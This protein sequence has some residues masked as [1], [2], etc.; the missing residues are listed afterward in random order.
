[1]KEK[2]KRKLEKEIKKAQKKGIYN[3]KI[4]LGIV[5]LILVI[6]TVI[7]VSYAY[8]EEQSTTVLIINA[9]VSKKITINVKAT[10]DGEQQQS[11][12]FSLEEGQ[13]LHERDYL[14]DDGI[15]Q[16]RQKV[17][18]DGKEIVKTIVVPNKIVNIVIKG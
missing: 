15:H 13:V 4:K 2:E 11:K 1:M 10:N 17:I 9:K 12:T 14:A 18:V 16:T 6:G 5:G 7:G 8:F 3:P